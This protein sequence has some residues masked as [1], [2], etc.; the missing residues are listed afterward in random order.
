MTSFKERLRKGETLVGTIL[1]LGLPAVAEM[2]SWCGF[3][4][5]W[6]DMEHG[7]LSLEQVQQSLQ[8]ASLP[9]LACSR[10]D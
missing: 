3:D 4:W 1:S 6:I 2:L 10:L 8:V 7:P 9:D 5:L